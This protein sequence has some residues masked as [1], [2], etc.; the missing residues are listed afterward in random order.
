MRIQLLTKSILL[1]MVVMINTACA[2]KNWACTCTINGAK[3]G[4]IIENVTKVNANKGCVSFGKDLGQQYGNSD[5]K[6]VVK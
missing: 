4:E 2:K 3:Y 1:L 5:Y 6:C